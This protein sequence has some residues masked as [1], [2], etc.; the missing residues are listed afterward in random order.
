MTTLHGDRS[1]LHIYA[2]LL[3]ALRVTQP[4]VIDQLD[5]SILVS[6][7]TVIFVRFLIHLQVGYPQ[8]AHGKYSWI[9]TLPPRTSPL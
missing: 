3:P 1:R 4:R 6:R 8:A 5:W 7:V 9:R 2:I